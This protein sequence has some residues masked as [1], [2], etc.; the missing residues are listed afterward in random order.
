MIN[1]PLILVKTWCDMINNPENQESKE[2]AQTMI[3]GAFDSP[4]DMMLFLNEHNL[5]IK[6]HG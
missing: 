5:S 6:L 4:V 2:H 1:P 3:L